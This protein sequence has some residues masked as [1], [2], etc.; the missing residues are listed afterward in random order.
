MADVKL[1]DT[2]KGI[3][4]KASEKI[5]TYQ[6]APGGGTPLKKGQKAPSAEWV[7]ANRKM[8]PRDEEGQFTYNSANGKGLKY[9]PSRGT[10]VPPFLKGIKLTFC[11]PGTKLKIEGEDGIKIKIMTID[12]TVEEIVH[13]CKQYMED[14][15]GF[16]GMGEGSS[17]TKKGR[18]SKEEKE[19]EAGQ[20][21]NVDPKTLSEGT[22][23]EMAEAKAKYEANNSS[24]KSPVN[25]AIGNFQVKTDTL[26]PDGTVTP[27][28]S[29]KYNKWLQKNAEDKAQAQAP[30]N[31]PAPFFELTPEQKEQYEA[32]KNAV[33]T[34]T[35]T[36]TASQEQP[37][38]QEDTAKTEATS[39]VEE[40]PEKSE[41][42]QKLDD[43]A[44]KEQNEN[45]I[46]NEMGLSADD[47]D[48]DI[49]TVKSDPKAFINSASVKPIFKKIKAADPNMKLGVIVKA[50]VDGKFKNPAQLKKWVNKKYG[51]K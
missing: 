13:K 37:Q 29:L 4:G 32:Q 10:T 30:V 8:Q 1:N 19:A 17:I 40:K 15:H 12:M 2:S 39:Q 22:Q 28:G 9:G 27:S 36:G 26:N 7:K 51:N 50:I 43:A 16:A 25:P 20:I 11:A 35:G 46:L 45:K 18:K 3:L 42:E 6:E 44:A 33:K 38:A 41:I 48:F 14:E 21:G 5:G 47:K 31:K 23:K 49:E 24:D 34:G